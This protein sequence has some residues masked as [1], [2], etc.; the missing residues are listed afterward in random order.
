MKKMKSLE[1]FRQEGLCLN[2]EELLN[3]DGG[4]GQPVPASSESVRYEDT[5]FPTSDCI[6]W[7]RKDRMGFFEDKEEGILVNY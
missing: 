6:R 7:A 3:A 4:I 1:D 5:S 2:K